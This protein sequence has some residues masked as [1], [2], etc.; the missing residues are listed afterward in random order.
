[1]EKLK[2]KLASISKLQEECGKAENKLDSELHYQQMKNAYESWV[3]S[4]SKPYI[5][6]SEFYIGETL[7]RRTYQKIFFPTYL[8]SKESIRELYKLFAFYMVVESIFG[9]LMEK[10]EFGN[11]FST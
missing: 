3:S 11:D 7:D 9:P 5:E 6:L 4:Y 1:M 2:E 8:D 10:E